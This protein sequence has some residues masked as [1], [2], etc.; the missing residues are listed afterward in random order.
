MASIA[1]HSVAVSVA[2]KA[3]IGIKV[4]AILVMIDL[5]VHATAVLLLSHPLSLLGGQKHVTLRLLLLF[6]VQ[7]EV[8]AN[9]AALVAIWCAVVRVRLARLRRQVS[10]VGRVARRLR[11]AVVFTCHICRGRVML[12][13][14][15]MLVLGHHWLSS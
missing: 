8:V 4:V 2:A 10:H 1:S 3:S 15:C 7:Q 6:V 13:G 14:A 12:D 9:L 11:H 5:F